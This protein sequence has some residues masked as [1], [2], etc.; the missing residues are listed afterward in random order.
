MRFFH[1]ADLHLGKS[2]RAFSLIEDQR[3]CLTEVLRLSQAQ[4]PDA[5]LLCGD[6]Y[7]RQQ[8]PADAV[9]LLDFFLTALSDLGI[10][11]LLNAGNHDSPERLGFAAGLLKARGVHLYGMFDGSFRT[12]TLEDAWGPVDFWML[13]YIRPA[14]VRAFYPEA[15]LPNTHRS[16][17]HLLGQRQ[18]DRSRRNVL[19]LHQFVCAGGW[20]PERSDS[21]TL[22]VGGLD[23]VD[24]GLFDGF[25]YVALGHLHKPQAVGRPQVRYAGSPLKYS[26]SEAGHEKS[27]TLVELD[28]EGSARI[29]ALPLSPLRDVRSLRGPLAALL[30]KEAT[31]GGNPEDFLFITLTDRQPDPD[32]LARL[33]KLYPHVLALRLSGQPQGDEPLMPGGAAEAQPPSAQ[34]LFAQLYQAQHGEAP[35]PEIAARFQRLWQEGEA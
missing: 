17:A 21:E 25:D 5:V 7:D 9:L 22:Q 14:H 30:S 10:P 33:R 27:L 11:V 35:P 32:A 26:Q 6:I 28:E 13:P 20:E 2:L 29:S 24:A 3:H 12:V 15:D 16:I 34:E 18:P 31:E 8:P 1:L 4:Q 19:L 23:A